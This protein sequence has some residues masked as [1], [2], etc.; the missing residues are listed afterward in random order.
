MSSSRA[1][2]AIQLMIASSLP[3]QTRAPHANH[4]LDCFTGV[5]NDDQPTHP[6]PILNWIASRSS[7]EKRHWRFSFLRCKNYSSPRNDGP[8]ITEKVTFKY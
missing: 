1:C 4:Q 5:R 8:G 2:E 3:S 6:S 7:F